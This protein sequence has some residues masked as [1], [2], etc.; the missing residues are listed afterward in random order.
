M[1][2]QLRNLN[3]FATE[4]TEINILRKERISTRIYLL[5]LFISVT[6]IVIYTV[7]PTNSTNKIVETPSLAE[8]EQL[9]VQYSSS[10]LC[11]CNQ[12]SISHQDLLTVTVTHHQLCSSDLIDPVWLSLVSSADL[13]LLHVFDDYR[14]M[15]GVYFR[16]LSTLCSR[17]QAAADKVID[18]FL[19]KSLLSSSA[20]S[21]S[22][23]LSRMDDVISQFKTS[24][25]YD[26]SRSIEMLRGYLHTNTFVSSYGLSWYYWSKV[27]YESNYL[28]S[29]PVKFNNS[30]SCGRRSDCITTQPFFPTIPG[31]VLGCSVMEGVMRSTLVSLFNQTLIDN[32]TLS[33]VTNSSSAAYP[34]SL[35][36]SIAS[37]FKVDTLVHDLVNNLFVEEWSFHVPYELFYNRCDPLYCSYVMQERNNALFLVSRLLGLYGGLTISW[38][39]LAPYITRFLTE[40]FFC[41]R[42]AQVVTC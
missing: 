25:A 26:F 27:M 39:F 17:A 5:L 40:G 21:Q 15:I 22:Q 23:F 10:L 29:A 35:N 37:R 36:I 16:M 12:I 30:C 18:G 3:F 9:L 20:M 33:M 8:Y 42:R 24:A 34:Q 41:F 19:M 32:M 11:P 28:W 4:S 31:L 38:R 7:A 13:S 6:I 14:V 2:N 1:K